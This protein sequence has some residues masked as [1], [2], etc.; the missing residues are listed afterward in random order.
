MN[1]TL[2]R[3]GYI[4]VYQET[5]LDQ[6]K[7]YEYFE[8][9]KV[10]IHG[11]VMEFDRIIEYSDKVAVANNN[12]GTKP[13]DIY[14]A[15]DIGNEVAGIYGSIVMAQYAYQENQEFNQRFKN[16]TNRM[17]IIRSCYLVIRNE[18]LEL[19][20]AVGYDV[21]AEIVNE[22]ITPYITR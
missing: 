11:I 12:L 14:T 1:K 8:D 10:V 20:Y 16:L 21:T 6:F 18:L 19:K 15:A 4:K 3:A 7:D 9:I 13:M 5:L 17:S 22:E 2:K